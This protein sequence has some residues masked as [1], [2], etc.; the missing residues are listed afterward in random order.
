VL[1]RDPTT[2]L[3]AGF[4]AQ[5][6]LRVRFETIDRPTVLPGVAVDRGVL[7]VDHGKLLS[8]GDVLHE[9][10]HLALLGPVDRAAAVTD[11]GSDGGY[12][13]GAIA[14]SWAALCE[15]GLEPAVVFHSRGYRGG[16]S[17]L[18]ENF[19]AGRF[20]GVPLLEWRGLTAQGEHAAELGVDPYPA[21][22]RWLAD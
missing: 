14:W 18:I 19:S 9:A 2:A 4:L 8:P 10:G 17:A 11:F 3:I 22:L 16:A 15:L 7:V 1:P 5:V 6:G 20:V 12:E 21:M 13:M